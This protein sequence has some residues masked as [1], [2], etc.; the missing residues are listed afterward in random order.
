MRER[1]WGENEKT[2]FSETRR[3]PSTKQDTQTHKHTNTTWLRR[4]EME[5][6]LKWGS[7]ETSQA[8]LSASGKEWWF[9]GLMTSPHCQHPWRHE[10]R[11][12]IRRV[13]S[14]YRTS[15]SVCKIPGIICVLFIPSWGN[16]A[17]NFQ[18]RDFLL[19]RLYFSTPQPHWRFLSKRWRRLSS[20][21]LARSSSSTETS[22]IRRLIVFF[23]FSSFSRRSSSSCRASL[24][25]EAWGENKWE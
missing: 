19:W 16:E 10:E 3:A 11:D 14:P 18:G 23:K 5:G 13:R 7:T 24:F 6:K 1:R 20:N 12:E 17:S 25:S 4:T 9:C 8:W 21:L 22:S 2:I 15:K